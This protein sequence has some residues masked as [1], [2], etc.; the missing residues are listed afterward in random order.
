MNFKLQKLFFALFLLVSACTTPSGFEEPKRQPSSDY[1]LPLSVAQRAQ[2]LSKY[3]DV[4]TG[5]GYRTREA[6]GAARLERHLQ[7]RKLL[8][9]KNTSVDWVDQKL[10]DISFK[11]PLIDDTNF[12]G[13]LEPLQGL[14]IE[15]VKHAVLRDLG[16]NP[17]APVL[18]IDSLGLTETEIQNLENSVITFP[19]PYKKTI[20]ILSLKEMKSLNAVKIEKSFDRFE[21]PSN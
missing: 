7:G 19:N 10:G 8:P 2:Q 5:Q 9:G 11:G 15:A 6:L 21:A 14:N 4:A 3:K 13:E 17:L 20:L 12:D 1:K 18:V 16:N